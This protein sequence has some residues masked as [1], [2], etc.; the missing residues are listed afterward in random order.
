[1]T[2]RQ[3]GSCPFCHVFSTTC[4][5]EPDVERLYD[6]GRIWFIFCKDCGAKGPTQPN[7][8]WAWEAWNEGVD[9]DGTPS[10]ATS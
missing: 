10:R 6:S 9:A 1:M 2:E 7:P 4:R 8:A 3:H 5:D